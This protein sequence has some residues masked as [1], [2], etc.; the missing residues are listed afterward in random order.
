MAIIKH[1]T[2]ATTA[3]AGGAAC[4][5]C[6]EFALKIT[7]LLQDDWLAG[8]LHQA[9]SRATRAPVDFRPASSLV[10]RGS[11][12]VNGHDLLDHGH[13]GRG[14]MT[15]SIAVNETRLRFASTDEAGTALK[16]TNSSPMLS[17]HPAPT[18]QR[19]RALLFLNL[20]AAVHYCAI[21]N[22]PPL[23]TPATAD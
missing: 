17:H 16:L 4:S 2:T 21:A 18:P 10:S 12:R 3:C 9:I 11:V 1:A 14:H 6:A 15:A 23:V 13:R 19:S 7:A 8:A 20:T 5:C 22:N